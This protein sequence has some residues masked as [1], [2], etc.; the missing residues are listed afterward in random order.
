M[1]LNPKLSPFALSSSK[2]E[3]R[4]FQ[5]NPIII[6]DP[7]T[8]LLL[9]DG[10]DVQLDSFPP[11]P[12]IGKVPGVVVQRH[13]YRN[14]PNAKLTLRLL[15]RYFFAVTALWDFAELGRFVSITLGLEPA[16]K[17]VLGLGVD[18][19]GGAPSTAFGRMSGASRVFGT[20]RYEFG[21]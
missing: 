15:D 13:R 17:V 2:G 8:P 10:S 12:P 3:R 20:L 4:V 7:L 21:R 14:G 16:K 9:L 19:T 11:A 18:L 5:Q 1:A 6:A